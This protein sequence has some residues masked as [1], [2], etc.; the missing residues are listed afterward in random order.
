M[1]MFLCATSKVETTVSLR[2]PVATS[3]GGKKIFRIFKTE[4]LGAV[5]RTR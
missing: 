1:R 2:E 4:Y 3:S 5:S